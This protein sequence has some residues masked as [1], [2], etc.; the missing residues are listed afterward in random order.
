VTEVGR[1]YRVEDGELRYELDMATESVA[2][3]FHVRATLGRV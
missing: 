1:R 3:T 2:R